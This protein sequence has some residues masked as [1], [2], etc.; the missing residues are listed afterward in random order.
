[1]AEHSR[2]AVKIQTLGFECPSC[3]ARKKERCAGN[4]GEGTADFPH[5]S[6]VKHAAMVTAHQTKELRRLMAAKKAPTWLPSVKEEMTGAD[7]GKLTTIRRKLIGLQ[8]DYPE[9]ALEI[10]ASI[11]LVNEA[12]Q[13]KR[14]E[15]R[16]LYFRCFCEKAREMLP[17]ETF[18]EIQLTAQR[19][20]RRVLGFR[21]ATPESQP[22]AF[23]PETLYIDYGK[24]RVLDAYSVSCQQGNRPESAAEMRKI[25]SF[26][27]HA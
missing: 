8:V 25:L 4:D 10:G 21:D 18:D 7:L 2:Y 26:A 24:K 1:M 19:E 17:R 23:D 6:R 15:R 16:S 11:A 13:K 14:S 9:K 22:M 20:E 27:G 12:I 5:W 3:K